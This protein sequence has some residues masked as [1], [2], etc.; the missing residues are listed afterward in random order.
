MSTPDAN[1]AIQDPHRQRVLREMRVLDTPAEECFDRLTRMAASL[2]HVPATYIAFVDETRDFCKSG[3]G[4][5]SGL[6]EKHEIPGD[7]FCRNTVAHDAPLV[8]PNTRAHAFSGRIPAVTS[9]SVAAFVGV[10]ITIDGTAIGAFCAI[11]F[12]T[13]AWS[14]TDVKVLEEL[15][16]SVVR[17]LELQRALR[18]LQENAE[19]ARA[20]R[21]PGVTSD[22]QRERV[23]IAE[24]D[25]SMR[26]LMVRILT[27]DGYEVVEARDGRETLETLRRNH[28]AVL[29]L[30]LVM[31]EIS[32]WEVLEARANE[33]ALRNVPVIVVSA[34]R[35]PDVARALAYGVYG[36]L[37]K[38]FDP[39][40]LRDL[41]KTCLTE[42]RGQ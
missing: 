25:E 18:N 28:T 16:R 3:Y 37:P 19:A 1:V 10:P 13:R 24:D 34:K 14:D 8:I 36:L 2:L 15:T 26:R 39:D 7:A 29:I 6:A 40:D 33:A 11:D 31:P 20:V 38:P 42:H 21:A 22:A 17:E 27:G 30:D 4:L 41:V 32:G 35:G 12:A 23:V 5:P 9:M